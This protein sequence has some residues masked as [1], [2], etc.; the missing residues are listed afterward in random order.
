MVRKSD[1]LI[2]PS[3]TLKDLFLLD[4]VRKQ[5]DS[6]FVSE[7]DS[8]DKVERTGYDPKTTM[9]TFKENKPT[10]IDISKGE[11][12][13]AL[14]QTIDSTDPMFLATRLTHE[15]MFNQAQIKHMQ[16]LVK[17][18]QRREIEMNS[19]INKMY[20]KTRRL[21]EL[22]EFRPTKNIQAIVVHKTPV[23]DIKEMTPD[24]DHKDFVFK[25]L[26]EI[27]V[28]RVN[29]ILAKCDEMFEEFNKI[30]SNMLDFF[31]K[32]KDILSE[33]KRKWVPFRYE[34]NK[35]FEVT[36]RDPNDPTQI[37]A[38][39]DFIDIVTRNLSYISHEHQKLEEKLKVI[40]F[41]DH[42]CFHA[43]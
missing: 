4:Q 32:G 12:G 31:A 33:K 13:M 8:L 23:V 20:V 19:I 37:K 38:T 17:E 36:K 43:I 7:F 11:E 10:V 34:L 18:L 21:E 41:V 5:E 14:V 29:L 26:E 15:S 35:L 22:N 2:L 9:V 30:I 1:I 28:Y 3:L 16:E 25:T 6:T 42:P 24:F 40:A 39:I 27:L